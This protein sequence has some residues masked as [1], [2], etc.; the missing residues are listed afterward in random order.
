V[1]SPLL[2][3]APDVLVKGIS[4]ERIRRLLALLHDRSQATAGRPLLLCGDT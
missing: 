3:R 4:Q 1:I 2:A